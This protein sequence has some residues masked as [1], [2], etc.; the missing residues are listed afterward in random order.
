MNK[1]TST[2]IIIASILLF[3]CEKPAEIEKDET[4]NLWKEHVK[5]QDLD[6]IKTNLFKTSE[7]LCLYGPGFLSK[8]YTDNS[9]KHY[10]VSSTFGKLDKFPICN[11]YFL[12]FGESTVYFFAT[13]LPVSWQR[14]AFIEMYDFDLDFANFYTSFSPCEEVAA[15]NEINQCLFAYKNKDRDCNLCIVTIEDISIDESPRLETTETLKLDIDGGYPQLIKAHKNSFFISNTNATYKINEQGDYKKV[16]DHV[17][18]TMFS[19][20][21]I[22]YATTE[23]DKLF[24]SN[25]DGESWKIYENYPRDLVLSEYYDIGDSLIAVSK[26]NSSIYSLNLNGTNY[27]YRELNCDGLEGNYLTSISEFKDSVYV[28]SL[29]GVFYKSQEDFFKEIQAE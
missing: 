15:I 26:V 1:I 27:S 14:K 2:T 7:S 24:I 18:M 8:I 22:L 12:A 9:V 3:A 25:D 5:F 17:F 6:K 20:N 28:T 11:D 19:H 4:P 23:F 21:E 10:A 16:L 29:T 13:E